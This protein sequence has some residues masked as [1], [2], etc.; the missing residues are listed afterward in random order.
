M[1]GPGDDDFR[2][3]RL[4]D[5]GDAIRSALRGPRVMS[6]WAADGENPHGSVVGR[7]H[8]VVEEFL[9]ATVFS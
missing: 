5:F 2:I 8:H 1:A 7:H 3:D 6:A 4:G 9:V